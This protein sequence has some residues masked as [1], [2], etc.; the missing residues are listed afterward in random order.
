MDEADSATL[1]ADPNV[2]EAAARIARALDGTLSTRN[3][4]T[5]V[6]VWSAL[7]AEVH[8]LLCTNSAKYKKERTLVRSTATPAIAALT[9]AITSR[10]PIE[11]SMAT[12]VA[13]VGLLLPF[14]ITVVAWCRAYQHGSIRGL[15]LQ[16]LK[17]LG[18][19][20]SKDR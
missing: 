3:S 8:E 18:K 10:F 19:S 16:E 6:T 11:V 7:R 4:S 17:A 9:G 14:R 20:K 12:A 5:L 1:E 13:S 15:E 2:L